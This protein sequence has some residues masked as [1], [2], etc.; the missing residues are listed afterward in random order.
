MEV[1]FVLSTVSVLLGLIP[2]TV[3]VKTFGRNTIHALSIVTLFLCAHD[4]SAQLSPKKRH[5]RDSIIHEINKT[6]ND[7]TLANL[8][9]GLA[10]LHQRVD[11]MK[12]ERYLDT[13][14]YYAQVSGNFFELSW[15]YTSLGNIR[16]YQSA[17]GVLTYYYK[18]L[19]V[20][21]SIQDENALSIAYN[22]LGTYFKQHSVFDTSVYF[23]QKALEVARSKKDARMMARLHG[24][25]SN[26]HK[27][28]GN[29]DDAVEGYLQ[30][31]ALAD[32]LGAENSK[33]INLMN[34][35]NLYNEQGKKKEA[36]I[37]FLEAR[38]IAVNQDNFVLLSY[39]LNNLG[40]V[41]LEMEDHGRALETFTASLSA[42]E[43]ID[44]KRMISANYRDLGNLKFILRAYD[45]ALM[46]FQKSYEVAVQINEKS[47]IAEAS[48]FLAK[49][50]RVQGDHDRAIK[51][52]E[53]S[54]SIY[55]ETG[56]RV[57]VASI[58][59]GIAE[60]LLDQGQATQGLSKAVEGTDM[61]EE[62]SKISLMSKG[63]ELQYLAHRTL[64]NHQ[65][66]LESHV[67]YKEYSDSLLNV[68]LVK[69]M[70]TL[71]NDYKFE[72]E[73][74][75]QK[76]LQAASEAALEAELMEQKNLR[77]LFVLGSAIFLITTFFI[78]RNYRSKKQINA[79]L[80]SKNEEITSLSSFKEAM[81]GMIAH[82][83][84]N[85]LSVIMGSP[86][87]KP[88]IRKMAGQMLHLVHNML[89]VHK[90]ESTEVTLEKGVY[91]LVEL[92]SEAKE[93]VTYLSTEK[94]V[95]VDLN[96]S[97][98]LLVEVDKSYI[99][100]VFINFL[101]NAIKYSPKNEV[102]TVSAELVNE[103]VEIQIMDNGIGIRE[104]DQG[105]I[106]NIFK[107]LNPRN[108]GA[109][110]STGL[111][112]SYCQ[113]ALR[114]H[115]SEIR[116]ASEIG[117]GTQFSFMLPMAAGKSS[118]IG[119]SEDFGNFRLTNAERNAVLAM[120]P[121]L[122]LFDLHQAAEIEK[123]L[124]PLTEQENTNKWVEEVLQAAYSNNQVHFNSLIRRVEGDTA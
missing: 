59:L 120:L 99:I 114:A 35:A 101:S 96:V 106:F 63:Y 69:Q 84:K 71:E 121:Q 68:D 28:M 50:Y 27:R 87:E 124:S 26:V 109:A 9:N 47:R 123:V 15:S 37:A 23:Y 116:V 54:M 14:I 45:E 70:T 91:P 6:P 113:L 3:A 75:E 64:G 94:N 12:A 67:K 79:Q 46:H 1:I 118:D 88:I 53:E 24:N 29:Y 31:I 58:L 21:D 52:Y 61:A 77:N 4:S 43:K 8:Y 81:T 33:G 16:D 22:A 62:L 108:T 122:K 7:S 119:L 90:F 93:H 76:S 18:A 112:L 85:P 41:Y 95:T 17:P 11:L 57:A 102:V 72:Q 13:A 30:A 97:E 44:N 83:L 2:S 42:A 36:L 10:H 111:G 66:A 110:S 86:S 5:L 80:E 103:Q 74:K 25:I 107:Q 34:V 117:K 89:D 60:V 65:V 115:G 32:S 40:N 20:A 38:D 39:T 48:S 100:R 55:V 105:Q 73:L 19:Q 49:C 56:E 92:I 82:D 98:G 78:Y 104:E 51:A